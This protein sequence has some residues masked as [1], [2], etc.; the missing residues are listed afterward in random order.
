MLPIKTGNDPEIATIQPNQWI[1]THS[2]VLVGVIQNLTLDSNN[3]VYVTYLKANVDG[4]NTPTAFDDV[5]S[6]QI[7]KAPVKLIDKVR[8]NIFIYS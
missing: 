7:H 6:W 4:D 2:N 3:D 1:K 8:R 5:P